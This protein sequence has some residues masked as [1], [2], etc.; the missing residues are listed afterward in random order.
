MAIP[1]KLIAALEYVRMPVELIAC[2]LVNLNGYPAVT[3]QSSFRQ[4]L[5]S[6][7]VYLL[8]L[9]ADRN[10]STKTLFF[11]QC[12]LNLLFLIYL[13]QQRVYVSLKP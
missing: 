8:A 3:R 2:S 10:I 1:G 7:P 6:Q 12:L 13:N 9:F 11:I 5:S 4:P